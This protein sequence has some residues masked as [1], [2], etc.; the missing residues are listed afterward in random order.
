MREGLLAASTAVGLEVDGRA[1]GRR[2]H[3]VGRAQG[4]HDPDRTAKR[5]GSEAGTAPSAG[6]A[7][8][9]T[10]TDL[11]TEGIVA[12]MVAGLSTRRYDAGLEPVG[13][14][15]HRSSTTGGTTSSL[16]L[17]LVDLAAVSD[18]S[19]QDQNCVAFDRGD[20]QAVGGGAEHGAVGVAVGL[21]AAL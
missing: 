8:G 11:L 7:A 10:S 19:D 18:S 15:A 5:H 3:R 20:R 1:D 6:G 4:K 12:R 9:P 17:A 21:A 13:G 14:A 16:D 2:G